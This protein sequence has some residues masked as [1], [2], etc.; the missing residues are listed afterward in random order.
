MNLV[1]GFV[2]DGMNLRTELLPRSCRILIEQ[3]LNLVVV[4]VEQR[5]DLLLLFGSQLQIFRQS[6]KFL[7][8]RSRP[9][10]VLKLLTSRGLLGPISLSHGM[11]SDS[12]QEHNSTGK[13]KRS[14]WHN[15]N[16][17][18]DSRRCLAE[19]LTTIDVIFHSKLTQR[20]VTDISV[21]RSI[22]FLGLVS[23]GASCD[24]EGDV[25]VLLV[26][27]ELLDLVDDGAEQFFG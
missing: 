15:S 13:R 16:L 5:P 10:D 6:S 27:A 2:A 3:R 14:I 17:R 26:R 21:R 23:G 24:D 11:T 12:K 22:R 19:S 1:V 20:D 7:V 18:E 25:V 4:L 8:D 9:M